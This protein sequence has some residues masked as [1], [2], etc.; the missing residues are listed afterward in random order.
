MLFQLITSVF[1]EKSKIRLENKRNVN[2]YDLRSSPRYVL[3]KEIIK[4]NDN[5]GTYTI[6]FY[7]KILHMPDEPFEDMK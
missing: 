6:A 1:T 7:N 4:R 5:D 2:F 3:N